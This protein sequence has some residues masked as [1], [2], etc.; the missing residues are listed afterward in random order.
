MLSVKASVRRVNKELFGEYV[1]D[2][3]SLTNEGVDLEWL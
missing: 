1:A 2:L 3:I